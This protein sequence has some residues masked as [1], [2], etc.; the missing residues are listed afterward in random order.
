MPEHLHQKPGCV[1]ARTRPLF[2][3]LFATLNARFHAYGIADRALYQTVQI[4]QEIGRPTLCSRQSAQKAREKRTRRLRRAVGV[5]IL[6]LSCG[7]PELEVFD[8]GLEKEV[9]WV[10]G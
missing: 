6:S 7:V 5:E 1:P 4:D 9:E 8:L 3:R 2:K 10:D